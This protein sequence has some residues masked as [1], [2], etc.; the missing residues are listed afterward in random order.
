ME[1]KNRKKV[2]WLKA[3][4]RARKTGKIAEIMTKFAISFV[5]RRS[6]K[7][8][9]LSFKGSKGQEATG[10]V[11][12]IAIRKDHKTLVESPLKRGDLFEIILIQVKGGSA[13]GPT[14]EDKKRLAKVK[15]FHCAKDIILASWKKGKLPVFKRLLEN[16]KWKE[17]E[18]KDIFK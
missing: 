13:E 4:E 18:P 5:S 8:Q 10:V 16:F 17:V 14:D 2:N 9:I 12:L 1:N 7:W 6:K 11:D 3:W 15:E